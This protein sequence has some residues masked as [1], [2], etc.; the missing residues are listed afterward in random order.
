MNFS[1]HSS[2]PQAFWSNHSSLCW[3]YHQ[4]SFL[5]SQKSLSIQMAKEITMPTLSASCCE[6][7]S[8]MFDSPWGRWSWV[9]FFSISPVSFLDILN[10][11]NHAARVLAYAQK[12]FFWQPSLPKMD[13]KLFPDLFLMSAQ[14]HISA[15]MS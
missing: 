12:F 15:S 6:A 2:I 10:E 11:V 4:M 3:L 1:K 14:L 7:S 5:Y 8:A 9:Y 13:E